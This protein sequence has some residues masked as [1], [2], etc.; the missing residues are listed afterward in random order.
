MEA[1]EDSS[2]PDDGESEEEQSAVTSSAAAVD[3]LERGVPGAGSDNTMNDEVGA[4]HGAAVPNTNA[5]GANNQTGDAEMEF[6]AGSSLPPIDDA[7]RKH[8]D[9][10]EQRA[11]KERQECEQFKA[12]TL[13]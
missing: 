11:A 2:T 12:M 5:S 10:A 8:K 6:V 9:K 4:G 7:K 1:I 13:D 3:D